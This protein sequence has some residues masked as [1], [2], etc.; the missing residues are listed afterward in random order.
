MLERG[1]FMRQIETLLKFARQTSDPFFAA[2]LMEKAVDL[3]SQADE[4][5]SRDVGPRPPDVVP[6]NGNDGSR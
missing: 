5:P 1:Y 2:F 6:E 3:K 4:A